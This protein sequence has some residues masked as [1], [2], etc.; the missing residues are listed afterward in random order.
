MINFKEIPHDGDLWELFARDF[1]QRMGFDIESPPDRG[2]DGGKDM[3]ITEDIKG[4]VFQGRFR[5]LVSCKHF[6]HSGNSVSEANEP[7]ILERV[8]SFKADGFIGFYSTIVSSGLNTR[9][10][11]LRDTQDIKDY[12][13][14]DYKLIENY[15]L[16][17]GFSESMLRYFPESYKLIR[18]LHLLMDKYEPL[19]CDY[20][21]KDLLEL[22]FKEE[23]MALIAFASHFSEDH[24]IEYIDDIY[25]ACKGD[26]DR[27]LQAQARSEGR[28]TGW[29]DI[30]DLVIPVEYLRFIFAIM[31]RLRA[32]HDVYS[33]VAY[34]KLRK[35]IIALS[36][37]VLRFTTQEERKRILEL[38]Q[39]PF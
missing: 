32:G 1:L 17:A 29:R 9:L 5:W 2:P 3:L 36:Q 37:K 38:L 26:C 34:K 30:S 20:C 22:L 7:S 12:R 11:L 18:P 21:E 31:N 10:R 14:F 35:I 15:L 23:Y 39:F 25:C 8:K 6:S 16:T 4:T 19:L 27:N 13:I 33:D 24:S 28:I